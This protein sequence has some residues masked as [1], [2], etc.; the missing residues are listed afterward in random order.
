[1]NNQLRP[2]VGAT[3]VDQHDYSAACRA[4]VEL[5]GT[6]GGGGMPLIPVTSGTAV[7]ERWS[8]ILNESNI[9]GIE[10][11]DLLTDE[12]LRKYTDLHGPAAAQLI[13][14]VVDL[15]RK[16]VVQ[17]CRGMSEDDPW[18]LAYLAVLG[19]VSAYPHRQ[20]TW[21]DLRADLTFQDVLIIRGVDGEGSASGLLSF[22]RDFTAMS[23]IELSRSKLTGGLQRRITRDFR[24]HR[25][26]NGTTT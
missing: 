21:N 12:E 5:C 19:D 4:V 14:V 26:S 23:A 2:R 3:A 6:W 1:V 24:S 10:R 11:T 17:T 15:E 20:N 16:P 18:H 25:G 8:R 9:D 22:L 13:R 7:D